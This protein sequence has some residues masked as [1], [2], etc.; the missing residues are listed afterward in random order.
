MLAMYAASGM[1]V[2]LISYVHWLWNRKHTD[3]LPADDPEA[4]RIA[5]S[6]LTDKERTTFKYPY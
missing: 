3:E 1:F 4:M 6:D 2:C 5:L